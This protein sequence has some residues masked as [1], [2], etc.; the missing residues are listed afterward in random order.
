MYAWRS[1]PTK[2]KSVFFS[3]SRCE[4]LFRWRNCLLLVF[5]VDV[6]LLLLPDDFLLM[7]ASIILTAHEQPF[8]SNS[9]NSVH[10]QNANNLLILLI[11]SIDHCHKEHTHTLFSPLHTFFGRFV[12]AALAFP[13]KTFIYFTLLCMAVYVLYGFFNLIKIH[14]KC[15]FFLVVHSLLRSLTFALVVRFFPCRCW[16]VANSRFKS[17]KNKIYIS[18]FI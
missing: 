3:S 4:K 6:P 18:T 1:Q 5:Y 12:F 14:L 8:L 13:S 15:A 10:T 2:I 17:N 11:F 7:F 9:F 16:C